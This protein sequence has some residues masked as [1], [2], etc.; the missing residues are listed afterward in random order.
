MGIDLR[1]RGTD[2]VRTQPEGPL[3]EAVGLSAGY[4][5]L[6]VLHE[7]NLSVQAGEVVAL[8]GPNGSGKTT[9]ILTLAGII[10]ASRG[11]VA[12]AGKP[13]TAPLHQRARAGMRLITEDRAVFTSLSVTDNLRLAHKSVKGPLAVFPE[14]RP[15]LRRR[16]GLLSGGEQQMLTLARALSGPTSLLLA[17][18]LSLGLAPLIVRR[19]LRAVREAA[20]NG[21][22]GVLL[23]EQHIRN[24][25]SVADRV[26]VLRQGRI[27][28]S[29]T[30]SEMGARLAEIESSYLN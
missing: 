21:G 26:Y 29:G 3:I 16:V 20:D 27:A 2:G 13:V 17:D 25:L 30:A 12:M 23:V 4:G 19:L 5:H 22:M 10:P 18:E 6:A 14:L 1:G 24:A 28:L 15:L 9:L 11:H 8:V 7:I